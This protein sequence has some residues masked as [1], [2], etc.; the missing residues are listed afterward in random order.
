MK[1]QWV[2]LPLS[3]KLYFEFF[4]NQLLLFS[5]CL[6]LSAV[7]STCLL[8]VFMFIFCV[9]LF[10][11]L[12]VLLVCPLVARTRV[13]AICQSSGEGRGQQRRRTMRA[14][15]TTGSIQRTTTHSP[16]TCTTGTHT[17]TLHNSVFITRESKFCTFNRV[18]LSLTP[19]FC[20]SVCS[21]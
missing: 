12:V 19:P 2:S 9:C 17:H 10:A 20:V 21:C 16:L 6:H 7:L 8:S 5:V 18:C 13:T 4:A 11:R 3:P 14:T 1:P 15:V